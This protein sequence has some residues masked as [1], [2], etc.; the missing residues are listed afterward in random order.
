MAVAGRIIDSIVDAAKKG[1]NR[2][3][4]LYEGG[5]SAAQTGWKNTKK[6]RDKAG[7]FVSDNASD[8]KQR[9]PK[10]VQEGLDVVEE[11]AKD[12]VKAT[13]KAG[14]AGK[15]TYEST[16]KER[17]AATEEVFK[18]TQA[19]RAAKD[20][21]KKAG[22]AA[23]Q[24]AKAAEKQAKADAKAA[25]KKGHPIIKGAALAGAGAAGTAAALHDWDDEEDL[26]TELRRKQANGEA[27]TVSE[28]K[29]LRLLED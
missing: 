22:K 8:I 13:K 14:K 10:K 2:L 21:E 29:L 12:T 24:E 27:L 26:V 1:K 15:K 18:E 16:V 23:K 11:A 9:L 28:R 4:G 5:K 6:A 25:K 19:K 20:A 17:D 7:K 3:E